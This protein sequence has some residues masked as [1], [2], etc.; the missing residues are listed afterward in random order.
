MDRLSSSRSKRDKTCD[1]T[2]GDILAGA[3]GTRKNLTNISYN[4][5]EIT[6]SAVNSVVNSTVNSTAALRQPGVIGGG[7]KQRADMKSEIQPGKRLKGSGDAFCTMDLHKNGATLERKDNGPVIAGKSFTQRREY[8]LSTSFLPE[9]MGYDGLCREDID[10]FPELMAHYLDVLE[11]SETAEHTLCQILD[12][13][14]RFQFDSIGNG[15]YFIDAAARCVRLDKCDLEAHILAG[16][17][18]FYAAVMTNLMRAIRDAWQEERWAGA[19]QKYHPES[20]LMLEKMRIADCDVMAALF[21]KELQNKGYDDFARHLLASEDAGLARCFAQQGCTGRSCAARAF[22]QW[23]M[24]KK[25]VDA[26]DHE[27]LCYL[28]SLLDM[29]NPQDDMYSNGPFG[30]GRLSALEIVK[31]GCLP[32]GS[33]YLNGYGSVML[34]DPAFAGLSDPINQAHYYHIVRDMRAVFVH[35]VPF[36]SPELASKIFPEDF[37]LQ[38]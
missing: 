27:T 16:S 35:G 24:D 3:M 18:Y 9:N 23:C 37:I 7:T 21:S 25:R 17:D 11:H 12:T 4:E 8:D 10:T 38:D 14:W 15:G 19:H 29:H 31:I 1:I 26:A 32:D 30:D 22:T 13:G 20:L 5:R 28:D 6:N 36:R 34:K 2:S 33:S